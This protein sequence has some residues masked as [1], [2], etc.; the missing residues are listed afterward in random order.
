VCLAD[1][2]LGAVYPTYRLTRNAAWLAPLQLGGL[3]MWIPR[4][5]VQAAPIFCVLI[6]GPARRGAQP[7]AQ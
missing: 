7:S 2:R 1:L 4:G 6:P 3:I 5:M